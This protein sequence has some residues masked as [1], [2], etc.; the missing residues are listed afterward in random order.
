MPAVVWEKSNWGSWRFAGYPKPLQP[1]SP[2]SKLGRDRLD[3]NNFKR[4]CALK[5]ILV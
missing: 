4:E 5:V 2:S 3:P 1:A